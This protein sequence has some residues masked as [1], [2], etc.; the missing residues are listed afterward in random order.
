MRMTAS[1]T[2]MPPE[3][4]RTEIDA[5]PGLVMLEFGALWC[6]HCRAAQPL[7]A[8]ALGDHPPV[9]HIRIEDGRGR[10]LGR[11]FQVK[12][13]PTL[14]LLRHGHEIARLVRPTSAEAIRTALARV[15]PAHDGDASTR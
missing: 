15:D 8:A 13:W 10:R 12:L 5:L 1:E 11:S 2:A 6:G 7:I 3:P 9:R 14:I 4:T